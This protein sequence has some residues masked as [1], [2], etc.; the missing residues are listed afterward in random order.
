MNYQKI[1][2]SIINNAKSLEYIRIAEKKQKLNY[3]ERHHIIPRCLG[4]SDEKENLV[5]L[6]AKE[7][8]MCHRLLC[9][10]YPGVR[11]LSFAM[12]NMI[13]GRTT[14]GRYLV[15]SRIYERIKL[16][17]AKV[18][19]QRLSGVPKTAEQ[20]LKM[21]ESAK[22][23]IVSEET[24]K[25]LS[26][27]NRDKKLSSD[28]IAKISKTLRGKPKSEQCK[29]NMRK[30]KPVVTCP[31]CGVSGGKNTMAQW[32]FDKCKSIPGNE[33][34][35]DIRT[36]TIHECPKCGIR[37]TSLSNLTRYHFD[38]CGKKVDLRKCPHCSKEMD[39]R[40]AKK[41]HFDNCKFK[42]GT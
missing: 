3:F 38:N 15:S 39:V 9:E 42:L 32:H 8:Y 5:L 40:N 28:T 33:H 2:D 25:L 20:R 27:I 12:W 36:H 6:T 21:S 1:Y 22:G 11:G 10:V 34:I 4:G 26:E 31:H 24:K 37:S 19:S 16:A 17:H 35:H 13:N 14:Q 23:R 7:H 41:Y 29:H 18:V 30:P